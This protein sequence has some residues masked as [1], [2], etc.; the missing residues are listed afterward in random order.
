MNLDLETIAV[1]VEIAGMII[2]VGVVEYNRH[3]RKNLSPNYNKRLEI[4]NEDEEALLDELTK[5]MGGFGVY[6]GLALIAQYDNAYKS[7]EE[8]TKKFDDGLAFVREIIRQTDEMYNAQKVH[9][10]LPLL[11]E[12]N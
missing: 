7:G 5:K 6:S 9:D 10:T 4:K 8:W 11:G 3:K 2:G 1:G 12:N